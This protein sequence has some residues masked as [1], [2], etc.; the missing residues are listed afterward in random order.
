MWA[1]SSNPQI[2]RDNE[3]VP[4]L[5]LQAPPHIMS[6]TFENNIDVNFGNEITP[7]QALN[8]PVSVS[9]PLDPSKEELYTILCLDPDAPSR[10]HPKYRCSVH[11][12]CVNIPN[13]NINQGVNLAPYGG[14][15]PPS[16]TPHRYI[17]AVY[18]QDRAV[19]LANPQLYAWSMR[20][21][22]G[23]SFDGIINWLI[24]LGGANTFTLV[25]AN[26]FNSRYDETV[27]T[28]MRER[29]S[30]CGCCAPLLLWILRKQV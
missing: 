10:E 30:W 23:K 27:L 8:T 28:I 19:N 26:W 3:I 25:A 12:V 4:E 15:G 29:L 14:P 21:R 16:D 13:C 6:I 11:W 17:F 22:V 9:W 24:Q 5:L 1:T 20:N 7:M 18:K 2:F